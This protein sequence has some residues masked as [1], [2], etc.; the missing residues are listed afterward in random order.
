MATKKLIGALVISFA[1]GGV[2]GGSALA[3]TPKK[4]A[5]IAKEAIKADV[6][7]EDTKA[8]KKGGKVDD[9]AAPKA[10][11]K[12]APAKPAEKTPVAP[13]AK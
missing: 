2:F 10:E 4:D 5:P 1:M 13:A 11:E 6:K 3:D 8:L 7:K 9:K 12:K